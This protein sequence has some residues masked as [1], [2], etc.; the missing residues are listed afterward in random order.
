M[1]LSWE[2]PVLLRP[3]FWHLCIGLLSKYSRILIREWCTIPYLL[4]LSLHNLITT[5]WRAGCNSVN[6]ELRPIGNRSLHKFS[7]LARNQCLVVYYHLSAESTTYTPSCAALPCWDAPSYV[8]Y[9]I[10]WVQ[11]RVEQSCTVQE[12]CHNPLRCMDAVHQ[13]ARNVTKLRTP[14]PLPQIII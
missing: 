9:M 1:V 10:H 7:K 11:K 6:R 3:L 13:K 4:L 12:F 5:R 14:V 2:I 8:R